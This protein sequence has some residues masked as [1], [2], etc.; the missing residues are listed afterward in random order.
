MN[1]GY[2]DAVSSSNRPVGH[3]TR[4]DTHNAV[5]HHPRVNKF[6]TGT[7]WSAEYVDAKAYR[8]ESA[9]SLIR[10]AQRADAGERAG[11]RIPVSRAWSDM[12]RQLAH[13]NVIVDYGTQNEA[14]ILLG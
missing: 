13:A 6:W 12:Q 11:T 14:T 2:L 7:G 9:K 8:K 5:I 3:V 10:L 4:H 1:T